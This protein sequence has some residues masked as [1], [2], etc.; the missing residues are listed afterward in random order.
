MLIRTALFLA[1]LLMLPWLFFA[2]DA[3]TLSVKN[4]AVIAYSDFHQRKWGTKE[5]MPQISATS[6]VEDDDGYIW[7]ATEG[8]LARFDGYRFTVY[9]GQYSPLFLNP[10]L[11]T[12]FFSSDG[13]L[14]VG[15]STRLILF[16]NNHFSELVHHDR[17]LGNVE[18]IAEFEGSIYTGGE[19]LH[20]ISLPDHQVKPILHTA[21]SITAILPTKKRLW[22]AHVDSLAFIEQERYFHIPLHGLEAQ[23]QILH[24]AW[25]DNRL[26]L[27]TSKGLFQVD[28]NGVLSPYIINGQAVIEPVQMLYQ[29]AHDILWLSL[30]QQLWQVKQGKVIERIT[31]IDG[32]NRAPWFVSAFEDR[33]GFLWLG[34]RT[35][36]LQR[37]RYDSSGNHSVSA[38]LTEPYIWAVLPTETALLVGGNSGLYQWDGTT[39]TGIDLTNKLPNPAVYSLMQDRANNIWLGTRRGMVTVDQ[40]GQLVR[41]YPEL[42]SLQIN[43]M[44][45]D[46]SGDVW[47][48]T[49]GGLFRWDGD[50]LHDETKRLGIQNAR[51]R[52]VFIDRQQRLWIATEEGMYRYSEGQ[53]EAFAAD[54]RLSATFVS[55]VGQLHD[56]RI[57]I[58]TL[59][60]GLAVY[61]N[62]QWYWLDERR[63]PSTTAMFIGEYNQH[64]YV[65]SLNGVYQLH[66]NSLQPG[67]DFYTNVLIDDFGAES[68]EDGVRCCN[69]SGNNKGALYNHH[70]YLPS[71][72]GLVTVDLRALNRTTLKPKPII[73]GIDV[74]G[75]WFIIPPDPLDV[76]SR[77]LRFQYSAPWFYRNSALRFRYRLTGYDEDWTEVAK[78]REAFYT[79]LPAG[80]YQF[81]VQVRLSDEHQWSDSRQLGIVIAAY[82][83]ERW[84]ARILMVILLLSIVII[85]YR[86]RL[87]ALELAR[88][89]LSSKVAERTE[90]LHQAN[91]RLQQASLTDALTG[92]HNRRYLNEVIEHLLARSDRKQ[93]GFYCLLLDI[94][95]FKQ[96]NDQLGHTVGDEIL[97]AMSQLLNQQI[98]NSDHLVRWGGEEFLIVLDLAN[99]VHIFMERLMRALADYH[100]PHQADLPKKI[101][102]SIGVC[103]HPA[104][105][106]NWSWS[107]SLILADKAMYLVKQHGKAGWLQLKPTAEAPTN[108]AEH[109]V[110]FKPIA[111]LQSG[112]FD[113]QGSG[114][115]QTQL[116]T[117]KGTLNE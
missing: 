47:V 75:V 78:R 7:V 79:N 72:D 97:I 5:G 87:H 29:D 98:R 52:M 46:A 64:L 62:D 9:D 20:Q 6:I 18:A 73:E 8:G 108:L 2:A 19:Q 48:A 43:G 22:I 66:L 25:H 99:P 91:E 30:P 90:E 67:A 59:Q 13:T 88:Q 27:G 95:D 44:Q 65:S 60:S 15:G 77:N 32:N 54:T 11:R 80:D 68:N 50:K 4:N 36:G 53:I 92:L 57:I 28:E 31:Q 42:D 58:G 16:R 69:G 117:T 12:L 49:L 45:Q 76:G 37:L 81:E 63:L 14:W 38:G 85:A 107:S 34:S 74:E 106:R 109:I 55:F 104:N 86:Y 84:W 56:N 114:H 102:C 101:N 17:S 39:F 70:L 89:K 83:Y 96:L 110:K 3:S 71:L 93:Q 23:Q 100:W 21:G 61:E 24:L 94:D 103:Y 105:N 116:Q 113:F 1:G 33:A 112:W 82:W 115:I 10:L 35:H 41:Q 111:L 26:L 51:I 40:H